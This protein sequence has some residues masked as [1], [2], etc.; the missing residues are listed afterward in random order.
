[1]KNKIVLIIIGLI[2]SFGTVRAKENTN[3]IQKE[4]ES[5]FIDASA[6]GFSVGNSG[7]EN[8]KALQRAVDHGGT[9]QVSQ[10]GTYKI[11]GTV[12]LRSNTSLEFGANVFLQKVDEQGKFAYVLLNEGA[13]TKKWDENITVKGLNIIV[14]DVD[15]YVGEI[16]GLRG[17]LAFFYIKDLRIE[18]FRCMDLGKAQYA[19]QI[20]TFE[21]IIV[22]DVIIKGKKDG[23][24]LGRG[25]RFTIRDGV[26]ETFDD[27]IALNGHDYSTGN[28]ELGWIEDGVVENCHDLNAENTVGYFCRILAGGW[29]DWKPGMEVQQSD[30]VVSNGKVYRVFMEP[31]GKVYKT[32]TRPTHESGAKVLDGINW[33]VV[34]NDSTYT[35]GVRNVVFR[36]IFLE[37]PRIGFS[38]HFDKNKF[39]RSYYPGAEVPKQEQLLF[40]N[41]RVLHNRPT[42]LFKIA[43]PVDVMTITNSSIKNNG[44]HFHSNGALP[45]YQKTRINMI[46]CVFYNEGPMD[47]LVNDVAEKE[48]ELNTALS[49]E[50]SDSF[51]AKVISE[52]G[53]ITVK[54]DL[55]GLKSNDP[56]KN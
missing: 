38:V 15:I 24:H 52:K 4:I 50:M 19:I 41:I 2:V 23:V 47:L 30:A 6:F 14:N 18:R 55:T 46:G 13:L 53:K 22:D 12:Y 27:A 42:D 17:Q 40:E 3:S 34:Q 8:M 36:D 26:F 21:D 48:I 31:D 44:I 49:V 33:V 20:C 11:A 37:K 1:M 51:S 5:S 10:P 54:S 9:I 25:K 35:A 56:D 39:S 16:Y 29:I 7:I 32:V 45:D 43:T 28:P